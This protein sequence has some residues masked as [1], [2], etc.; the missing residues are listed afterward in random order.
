MLY[1]A[2]HNSVGFMGRYWEE[3]DTVDIVDKDL[4]ESAEVKAHFEK[5]TKGNAEV[6]DHS[7]GGQFM[8]QMTDKA[9]GLSRKTVAELKLIAAQSGIEV[10]PDAKKDDIIELLKKA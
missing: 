9:T 2:I 1:K 6:E 8:S 5:V 3:G 4:L 7:D 10:P